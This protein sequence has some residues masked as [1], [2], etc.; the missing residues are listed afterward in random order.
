MVSSTAEG[1]AVAGAVVATGVA[2][3]MGAA[4]A[5]EPG[6]LAAAGSVV[7][8]SVAVGVASSP[9]HGHQQRQ[10]DVKTSAL[11]SLPPRSETIRNLTTLVVAVE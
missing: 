9:P 4:V 10:Q 2:V 5:A 1:V 7:A 8:A 6:V 11:H 3:G